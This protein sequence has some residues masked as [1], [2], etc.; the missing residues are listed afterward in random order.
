MFNLHNAVTHNLIIFFKCIAV[1][2]S[3]LLFLM[4][5]LTS[6]ILKAV[7]KTPSSRDWLIIQTFSKKEV[8]TRPDGGPLL[9]EVICKLLRFKC[10]LLVAFVCDRIY[11]PFS[12][13]RGTLGLPSSPGSFCCK[14]LPFLIKGLCVHVA[15]L[16]TI[17]APQSYTPSLI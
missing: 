17:S 8:N 12:C 14:F 13:V 10:I 2:G 11:K 9:F 3:E 6:A 16:L 4:T 1:E 5:G 7:A 15:C